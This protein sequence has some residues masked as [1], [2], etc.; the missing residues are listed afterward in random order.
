MIISAKS[1][2]LAREF[3]FSGVFRISNRLPQKNRRQKINILLRSFVIPGKHCEKETELFFAAVVR[4]PRHPG[5]RPA[6]APAPALPPQVRRRRR[7][8]FA[9]CPH[10]RAPAHAPRQP[11][12]LTG[13]AASGMASAAQDS[14]GLGA[15]TPDPRSG[16]ASV[17]TQGRASTFCSS[18]ACL[19]EKI[20]VPRAQ[21]FSN[22]LI[23]PTYSL[24]CL[25]RPGEISWLCQQIREF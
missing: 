19:P 5:R 1:T 2:H 6:Q 17:S 4:E 21:G 18:M 16:E 22:P 15:R 3:H 24:Y 14:E 12:P 23:S 20:L 8:C 10:A 7:C 11:R 9:A 25:Q 13:A